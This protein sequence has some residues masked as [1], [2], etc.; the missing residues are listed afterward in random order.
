[1]CAMSVFSFEHMV[2]IEWWPVHDIYNCLCNLVEAICCWCCEQC[3]YLVAAYRVW[4]SG[5]VWWCEPC[6]YLVVYSDVNR[7]I[8][9]NNDGCLIRLL[10]ALYGVT[11]Y[12][13]LLPEI[14]LMRVC[15]VSQLDGISRLKALKSQLGISWDGFDLVLSVFEF[16]ADC[17]RRT[18]IC[19]RTRMSHIGSWSRSSEYIAFCFRLC[20][21]SA[22]TNYITCPLCRLRRRV[23]TRLHVLALHGS[24]STAPTYLTY[25]TQPYMWAPPPSQGY[26]S[27]SGAHTQWGA[28]PTLLALRLAAGVR[29]DSAAATVTAT[30]TVVCV[31]ARLGRW[32]PWGRC[33]EL[34]TFDF[35]FWTTSDAC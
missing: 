33:H 8:I 26:S 23:W 29:V 35:L 34:G 7:V 10:M 31:G 13:I 19:R 17:F 2:M 14:F 21:H 6:G 18:T 4:L 20:G 25:P 16:L 3:D 9:A 11:L 27:W 1:M 30:T 22:G 24:F 5:C 28:S 15:M 12:I 32:D